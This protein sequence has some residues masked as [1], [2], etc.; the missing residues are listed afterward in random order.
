MCCG[1]S[2]RSIE[3]N[4]ALRKISA[5]NDKL[6]LG[7]AIDE[8][9]TLA[10]VRPRSRAAL[11]ARLIRL[12]SREIE[13]H[14]L[15]NHPDMAKRFGELDRE[16]A[17]RVGHI[18][19]LRARLY[20]TA[21]DLKSAIREYD[22]Q[23]GRD[24]RR[25]YIASKPVEEILRRYLAWQRKPPR[26]FVETNQFKKKRGRPKGREDNLDIFL[27]FLLIA[28]ENAGGHLTFDKNY[29]DRGP[30]VEA[31]R[32]LRPHIPFLPDPVPVRAIQAALFGCREGVLALTSGDN[33][34]W[35][36]FSLLSSDVGPHYD[37]GRAP[38]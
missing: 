32:A 5:S 17:Q 36:H 12:I 35:P 38:A 1:I 2:S 13:E 7:A 14:R 29:P 18:F 30:L 4:G 11:R 20:K 22:D 15:R 16:W 6:G 34:Y 26:I 31:L 33:P 3:T 24:Y 25:K 37:R 28:I 8:I 19:A 10:Q 23:Y 9:M 27:A 21:L